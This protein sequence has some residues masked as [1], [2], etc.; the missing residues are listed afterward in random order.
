ME[1]HI[2]LHSDR[3][4]RKRTILQ[5]DTNVVLRSD[6]SDY[7]PPLKRTCL[8]STGDIWCETTWRPTMKLMQPG[9]DVPNYCTPLQSTCLQL[10]T[11]DICSKT[12][13]KTRRATKRSMKEALDGGLRDSPDYCPPIKR[14]CVQTNTEDFR[15][16]TGESQSDCSQSS[17]MTI[18][19][20]CTP[21]ETDDNMDAVAVPMEIGEVDDSR[22]EIDVDSTQRKKCTKKTN[23]SRKLAT[24]QRQS[25]Q[26]DKRERKI[27]RARRYLYLLHMNNQ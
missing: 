27:V 14:T 22:M 5:R 10:F 19:D 9:T 2:N 4:R 11:G 7:S 15:M 16:D 13:H 18:A 17:N 6:Q 3:S 21:M 23:P 25:A 8:L 26:Q 24:C 12:L 20:D 1:L